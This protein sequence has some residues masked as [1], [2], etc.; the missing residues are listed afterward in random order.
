[1]D[2]KHFKTG[3]KK[4]NQQ[5]RIE[6]LKKNHQIGFSA[7]ALFL[8]CTL[9]SSALFCNRS[10]HKILTGVYVR[11]WGIDERKDEETFIMFIIH[12]IFVK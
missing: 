9:P 6:K 3:K 5:Q 2:N 1:M 12:M 11:S 7:F 8:L 10:F 4:K